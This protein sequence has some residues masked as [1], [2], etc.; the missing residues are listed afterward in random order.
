ML[1][2]TAT[3]ARCQGQL[4]AYGD[5]SRRTWWSCREGARFWVR[6]LS[7]APMRRPSFLWV[8]LASVR[9][10]VCLCATAGAA[11]G[12]GQLTSLR[13][14]SCHYVKW[15]GPPVRSSPGLKSPP[16]WYALPSSPLVLEVLPL[17][18]L[19]ARDL[20]SLRL[21]PAGGSSS[22]SFRPVAAHGNKDGPL[23][24]GL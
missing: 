8:V 5:G 15:L 20:R 21:W 14:R 16:Q 19:S 6:S 10:P 23:A 1:Y 22:G 11:A 2:C 12:L 24:G 18:R 4:V 7:P 13:A 3:V 17:M 9:K